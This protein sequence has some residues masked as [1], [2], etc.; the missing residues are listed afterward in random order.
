MTYRERLRRDLLR[1]N[2]IPVP[3]GASH[4]EVLFWS[5]FYYTMQ[6]RLGE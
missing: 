1:F 5:E 2:G 3:R 6:Q 4:A